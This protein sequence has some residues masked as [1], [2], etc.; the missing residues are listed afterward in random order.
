VTLTQDQIVSLLQVAAAY[1][2]RNIGSANVHAWH[3]AADRE[4]W[5]FDDAVAAIK[6][7]YAE[8]TTYLLPAHVTQRIRGKRQQPAPPAAVAALP[9]GPPAAPERIQGLIEQVAARLGWQRINTDPAHAD[10]MRVECPHCH[11]GPGRSCTRLATRGPRR[12]QY[13]PLTQP[14]PSRRDIAQHT[15]ETPPSRPVD[16]RTDR[17]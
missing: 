9:A 8:S 11:A 5:V 7:H 2:N 12:G 17:P 13:V 14:H 4:R 10:T 1:D 16:V 3:D 6:A 15:T